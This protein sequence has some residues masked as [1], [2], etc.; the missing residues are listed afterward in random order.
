MPSGIEILQPGGALIMDGT[1]RYSRLV[2]VIDPVAFGVPGSKTFTELDP[3]ALDFVYF[4]GG[5]RLVVIS[6][7]GN[8][9]SWAYGDEYSWPE[10][11]GT[12]RLMVLIR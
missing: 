11:S 8:Q 1:Q 2:E 7:A 12:P 4:Q 5:G 10:L 3:A 9:L 6:K